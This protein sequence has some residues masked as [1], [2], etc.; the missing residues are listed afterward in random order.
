MTLDRGLSY[1][2]YQLG[3]ADEWLMRIGSPEQIPLLFLPP[4]LEEMN[5]TRAFL[6][7]IMRRL[8]AQGFGCW[9]PD[10]PGTGESERP[11]ESCRW[12]DWRSAAA[13]AAEHVRTV[14]GR[15]AA[16]VGFR[17]GALLDD[18]EASGHWRF[19]PVEGASLARD[20]VR[21]SLV[22]AAEQPGEAMEL[23]GYRLHPD[24]LRDL[25]AAH[26]RTVAPLR[27]VRLQSVRGE[28]ELK[29]PGPALWRR[30]EPGNAPDLAERLSADIAA[31][32][33]QC[34]VS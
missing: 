8:A 26:V 31:W 27:T 2:R 19:A 17:G 34:G 6:A 23:A 16:L 22:A 14:T 11:L 12:E 3:D 33:G 28:A 9:L 10:L 32:I 30:S 24:L 7:T 29:V 21:S 20:L 25:E 1:D 5:R 15:A 18:M 13:S 4:L